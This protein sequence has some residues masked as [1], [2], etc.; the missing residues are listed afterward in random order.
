MQNENI[1][2]VWLVWIDD[3]K[4]IVSVKEC[5]GGRKMIFSDRD[6]GI[7]SVNKLILNGYRI[8]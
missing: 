6:T 7:K 2:K 4:K 8:G 1:K 5:E 3:D